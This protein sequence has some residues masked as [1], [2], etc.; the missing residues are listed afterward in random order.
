MQWPDLVIIR[1]DLHRHQ[2]NSQTLQLASSMV[3][4]QLHLYQTSKSYACMNWPILKLHP[5]YTDTKRTPKPPPTGDQQGNQHVNIMLHFLENYQTLGA[6][7]TDLFNSWTWPT[8]TSKELQT[9]KEFLGHT[10]AWLSNIVTKLH[11][12]ISTEQSN[13]MKFA[14]GQLYELRTQADFNGITGIS[15]KGNQRNF[16]ATTTGIQHGTAILLHFKVTLLHF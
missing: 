9:Y 5:T 13:K 12:Y 3:K 15:I 8:Q 10:P 11:G 6:G 7:C 1:H 2:R 4:G 14:N 16:Q